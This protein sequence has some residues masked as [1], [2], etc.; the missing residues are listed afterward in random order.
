M[1]W[2]DITLSLKV[3]LYDLPADIPGI[4]P[5]CEVG[6]S[7][8]HVEYFAQRFE[9]ITPVEE[10]TRI[11]DFLYTALTRCVQLLEVSVAE[12]VEGLPVGGRPGYYNGDSSVGVLL[13]KVLTADIRDSFDPGHITTQLAVEHG[14]GQLRHDQVVFN[15]TRGALECIDEVGLVRG[16]SKGDGNGYGHGQ[17]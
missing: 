11:I 1:T 6:L 17:H 14:S 8:R 5:W 2:F 15:E 12:G 7:I 9:G 3:I 10:L 13:Q 4:R 16:N